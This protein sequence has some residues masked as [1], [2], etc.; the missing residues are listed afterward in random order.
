MTAYEILRLVTWIVGVPVIVVLVVRAGR[1]TVR[2][3]A[4]HRRLLD[5]EAASPKDP[6]TRLAELEAERRSR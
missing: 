6:W 2:I 5:E 4:L 3:R 1:T